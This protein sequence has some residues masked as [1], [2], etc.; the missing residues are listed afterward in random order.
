MAVDFQIRLQEVPGRFAVCRLEHGVA[1][2]A[3][4][5]QSRV[6]SVIQTLDELTVVCEADVVPT[7]VVCEQPWQCMRVAGAMPFSVTGVLAAI[8][9]P[10]AEAKISVFAFST[11]DTDYLMVQESDWDRAREAWATAELGCIQH[12]SPPPH[13]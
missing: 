11:Y 7:G 1:I 9:K 8:T 10:L 3:W 13:Y 2:P 5:T 4:V 12:T 6:F